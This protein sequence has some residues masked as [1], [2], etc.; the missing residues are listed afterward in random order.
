MDADQQ[1]TILLSI[2]GLPP[3][4]WEISVDGAS[5]RFWGESDWLAAGRRERC[6]IPWDQPRPPSGFWVRWAES[7]GAAWWPVNVAD[8]EV[9]PPP[10]ELQ[11]LPLEVLI[12]I[13]SSARPLHRVLKEYLQR[14]PADHSEIAPGVIVDPHKRVDTSRFLL[15]RTRR[16]SGALHSLRRRLK[17]PVVT[18]E[19][20]RW[21][22]RGPVGIMALAEA[23][24]REAHSDEERSFLLSELL[25]E[26]SRVQ[27][28]AKP[29][30]LDVEVHRREI[31]SVITDLIRLRPELGHS[32]PDN[33]R[34]YVASVIAAVGP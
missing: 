32:G 16:I 14:R 2:T 24:I 31:R 34:H 20:L 6:L 7:S 26:L 23:L 10:D 28:A 15:Q 21:R 33:L 18:V 27:P 30:C 9:L 29:G 13:L 3:P 5:S 22:L 8:G 25:L 4:E 19:F 11:H 17:T 1:A 12:N